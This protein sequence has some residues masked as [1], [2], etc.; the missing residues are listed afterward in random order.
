MNTTRGTMPH[1]KSKITP[2]PSRQFVTPSVFASRLTSR[3]QL[4]RKDDHEVD[5]VGLLDLETGDHLLVSRPDWVKYNEA[6]RE[7]IGA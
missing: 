7:A 3:S 6:P 4:I 2:L 1:Q 5:A